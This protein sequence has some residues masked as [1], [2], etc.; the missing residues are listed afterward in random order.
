MLNGWGIGAASQTHVEEL[1]L[2]SAHLMTVL[3]VPETLVTD[4]K[5]SLSSCDP[6]GTQAPAGNS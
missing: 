1:H 3:D 6:F 4:L 5:D 2:E